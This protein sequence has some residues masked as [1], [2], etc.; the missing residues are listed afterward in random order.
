MSAPEL[1]RMGIELSGLTKSFGSVSAVRGID[2]MIAPGETVALLGPNGAGKTT[3]IDTVLGLTR[4][5]T[6]TVS[7]FG[8]SP[9]EAVRSGWVVECSR[10]A[11]Y[12][13]TS[14]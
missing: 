6:G 5:D 11:H 7:V 2:L 14:R 9:G 10:P 13:I 12:R 1:V 8:A 3:T 4:P